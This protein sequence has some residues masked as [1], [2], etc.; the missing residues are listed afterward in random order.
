M[1]R[2]T[3][4]KRVG[5]KGIDVLPTRTS[6]TQ[7]HKG[8]VVMHHTVK[9]STGYITHVHIQDMMIRMNN[10]TNAMLKDNQEN[11]QARESMC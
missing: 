11:I 4:T 5:D 7:S 1:K 8:R 9:Q 2:M 10:D 3:K 6:N